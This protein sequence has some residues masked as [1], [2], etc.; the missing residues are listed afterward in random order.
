MTESLVCLETSKLLG[1]LVK[2]R[3]NQR[4]DAFALRQ[5]RGLLNGT[6]QSEEV[7]VVRLEQMVSI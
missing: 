5:G 2:H 7:G 4:A 1:A 6:G 3:R